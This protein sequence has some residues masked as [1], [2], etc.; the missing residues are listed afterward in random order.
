MIIAPMEY[1]VKNIMKLKN[2]TKKEAE[3]LVIDNTAR[4]ENYIKEYVNFDIA[5]P[6]HYDLVINLAHHTTNGVAQLIIE[7]MKLKSSH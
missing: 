7:G 6:N 2:I 3:K 5:D 4:R 1:K